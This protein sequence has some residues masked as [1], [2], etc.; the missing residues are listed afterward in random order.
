MVGCDQAMNNSQNLKISV[1]PGFVFSSNHES[2][3]F[4]VF[5][6]EMKRKSI[7]ETKESKDGNSEL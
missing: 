1:V 6:R 7:G 3:I 4:S 2:Y 5:L